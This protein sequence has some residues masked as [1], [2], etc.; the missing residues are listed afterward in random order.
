[1]SDLNKIET[2]VLGGGCFWCTEAIFKQLKG[3]ISITS[4]YAGG[5]MENPSYEDVTSGQTGHAEVIR[6]MYDPWE[7]KF[8]DLLEV[9]FSVHD[10]TTLNRQGNDVGA[11]YRSIILFTTPEQEQEIR[12]KIEKIKSENIFDDPIVT[13]V[14]PLE[15]FYQ[16]EDYHRD[17]FEHNKDKMYCQLIINPKLKKFKDKWLNLLKK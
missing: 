3:V 14:K 4:G 1:M 6:V 9:F 12:E 16:A 7:I 8:G 11:Q 10:P 15:E 13:E 5:K 2:I 17:Y